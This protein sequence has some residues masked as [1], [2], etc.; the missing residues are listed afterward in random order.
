MSDY[1]F[2][3]E[4]HLTADQSR[5]L[6]EVQ[7][8]AAQAGVSL[9]LTGG[10]IR[11]MLGGFPIRDLD[12]TVEGNAL[13][14][15]RT[16][17]QSA[18]AEILS[19][20]E[21]RKVIELRFPG[22][23][24]AEIGMARQERYAKPG[25][26]A[27]VTPATIHE[28]LR[29]RDFTVNA[30]GLSLNKASRGLL[31]DP[32]NGLAELE[33]KELRSVS[34]YSLYDQPI[35]LFRLIRFKVRLGFQ[36]AERTQMQYDNARSAEVE[37]HIAAGELL[38]EMHQV[39]AEQNSAD[40]LLAFEQEKLLTLVSP[41]LTGA[42]VNHAGFSK[43]QKAKQ[44]LPFGVD[45]HLDH[46]ALFFYFL[47]E[48]LTPKEK[49]ALV[50]T[51]GMSKDQVDA[52]QRLEAKA[53]KLEK[54]LQST[55]L[56]KPSLLYQLLSKVPGEQ[57]LFLLTKS[58]QRLVLDRIRNYLQ[59]YLLTAQEVTDKDV[60]AAGGV[61]GT[62]KFQKLKDQMIATKLDARPKKVA[63]PPAEVPVATS[64]SR[65]V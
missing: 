30:F 4:N 2:M 64:N 15:A 12:F 53:K 62:P 6:A 9:F 20:D 5:V 60:E 44:L 10:A 41:A 23:V 25:G 1:M 42:K 46:A 57:M 52:W 32:A 13:K 59:K 55:K 29:R 58:T 43:L 63:E 65:R 34:N 38:D 24:T 33:R 36:I 49:S 22:G 17:A 35:R 7:T 3:L 61:P 21:T 28:D 26:K 27:H 37:K 51:L 50:E 8:A 40:M 16:L 14:L 45:L 47:T 39:A 11:D 54:D 56:Q 48:K 19:T 18:G 31:L